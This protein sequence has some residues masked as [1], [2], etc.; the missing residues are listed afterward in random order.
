M[1]PEISDP[2]DKHYCYQCQMVFPSAFAI[3]EHRRIRFAEDGSHIHCSICGVTFVTKE[4]LD[5][6]TRQTH[7][8]AQDLNCPGCNAHFIRA[9]GLMAHLE[10][11]ECP[12]ISKSQLNA[13]RMKKLEFAN[14]L[15]KRA[16]P[17]FPNFTRLVGQGAASDM[18]DTT[19][20]EAAH[21]GPAR[22]PP[23][24][25]RANRVFFK[26][27]DFPPLGTESRQL[28]ST[29]TKQLTMAENK[30][31]I[32]HDSSLVHF[33][34]ERCREDLTGLYRCPVRM[35]G[36]TFKTAQGLTGH[37]R[38]PNVHTTAGRRLQ[39]PMCYKWFKDVAAMTAHAESQSKRCS[40]RFS[41]HYRPFIDQLTAG[42]VDAVGLHED[43]TVKYEVSKDATSVL[44]QVQDK[45]QKLMIDYQAK[46]L[47]DLQTYWVDRP[48][49][50]EE[51]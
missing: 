44:Y 26:E 13:R 28:P 30:R 9:A 48:I 50:D 46:A 33:N 18:V 19:T 43:N 31:G 11:G 3:A 35:C 16:S 45:T 27:E 38:Q 25:S 14:E 23:D 49:T 8:K 37:L 36:Q 29:K 42:V 12:V 10:R 20:W 2:E 22:I 5:E 15:E 4:A 6:H 17:S 32:T 41:E 24:E 39:C 47:E 7:A 40:I 21:A 51:W 34:A 1:A